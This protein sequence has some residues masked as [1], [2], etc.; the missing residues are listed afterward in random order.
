MKVINFFGAPCSGKSRNAAALFALMKDAGFEVELVQE[1]AK[2]LVWAK[3]Y[4][5]L[6]DQLY[7]FAKQNDRLHT[8]NNEVDYVISDSPLILSALYMPK[9]Y[10]SS[11]APFVHEIFNRYDNINVFLRR[12]HPYQQKGRLHNE[13]EAASINN[14]L[15][16]YLL[17]EKVPFIELDSN[18]ETSQIVFGLISHPP[19][20]K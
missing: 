8:L 19:H 1:V 9:D 10:P 18:Q 4:K 14:R 5:S 6:D 3:R 20:V 13:T 15:H 2:H 11:F 12:I 16:D 17:Q 7:I